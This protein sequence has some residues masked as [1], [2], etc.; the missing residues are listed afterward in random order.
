MFCGFSAK[1]K[2]TRS[3]ADYLPVLS[4]LESVAAAGAAADVAAGS[5]ALALAWW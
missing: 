2:K 4:V 5:A 1:L 3:T